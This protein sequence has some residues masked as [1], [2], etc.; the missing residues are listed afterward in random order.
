M[1]KELLAII[2]TLQHFKNIILNSRLIIHT[3]NNNLRY[4]TDSYNKRVQRWKLLLEEFDYSLHF[5][6]G[7]NYIAS[8]HIYRSL[9][10]KNHKST[11]FKYNLLKIKKYQEQHNHFKVKIMKNNYKKIE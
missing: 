3:D 7:K 8:D 6:K 4:D 5:I 1:E 11:K 9:I 2:K 10:V